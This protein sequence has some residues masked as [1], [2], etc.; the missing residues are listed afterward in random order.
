MILLEHVYL[1]AHLVLIIIAITQLKDVYIIVH[2]ELLQIVQKECV[3]KPA[4]KVGLELIELE[5]VKLY[6]LINNLLMI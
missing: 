1:N 4:H 5:D 2:K 6:A 3:F